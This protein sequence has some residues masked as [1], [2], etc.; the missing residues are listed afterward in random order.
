MSVLSLFRF[1]PHSCGAWPLLQLKFLPPCVVLDTSSNSLAESILA[2]KRRLL[3]ISF[4]RLQ[5]CLAL[6]FWIHGYSQIPVSLCLP[7]A[8]AFPFLQDNVF[9]I[10]FFYMGVSHIYVCVYLYLYIWK[11][12][13]HSHYFTTSQNFFKEWFLLICRMK[14][15]ALCLFLRLSPVSNYCKLYY[16]M[17]FWFIQYVQPFRSVFHTL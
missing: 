15:P 2:I 1:H 10:F 11:R 8:L 3:L 14:E 12:W 17:T 4:Q 13:S 6:T 9:Y 7:S 16:N 5:T